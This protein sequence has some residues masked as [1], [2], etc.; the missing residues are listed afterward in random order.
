MSIVGKISVPSA[1]T[2]MSTNSPVVEVKYRLY[3]RRFTGLFGFVSATKLHA[4]SFVL[5]IILFQIILGIV[6]AMPGSWFG[7]ITIIGKRSI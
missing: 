2:E 7:P 4:Q 3:K 5:I 6:S 1:H